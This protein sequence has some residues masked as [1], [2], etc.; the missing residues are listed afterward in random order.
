MTE[1]SRLSVIRTA[2]DTV[3]TDYA[4]LLS[5]SLQKSPWD[6]A[7]LATFAELVDSSRP[8]A[9]L[10]CGPGRITAHLHEL[11]LPV[12]GIDLSAAMIEV[13]RQAYPHL[14]FEEGQLAQLDLPGSSLG[15]A[16]AWYS[17]IHTPQ[18]KFRRSSRSST[19]Y[20]RPAGT[21]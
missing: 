8:I 3:A 15:G 21:C 1:P 16:V 14:H 10:G 12:S 13:A 19:V 7:L 6:R 18:A 11:G 5:D 2:Y 17:I 4:E 20:S 9:D